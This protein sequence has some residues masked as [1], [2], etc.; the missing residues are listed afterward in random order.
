[1]AHQKHSLLITSMG[2]L[3]GQNIVEMLQ[4]RRHAFH[5]AGLNTEAV[6][7]VIFEGD[8]LWKSPPSASDAYPDFLIRVIENLQPDFVLPGRDSDVGILAEIRDRYPNWS[9]RIPVGTPEAA[10]IMDDKTLSAKFAARNGLPFARSVD[11]NVLSGDP[12]AS[13]ILALGFPQIAKPRNGFG[14]LGARYLIDL[15]QALLLCSLSPGEY[16]FQE[17]IDPPAGLSKHIERYLKDQHAGIPAF[18]HLPDERQYA[19]Q[20]MI[21]PLGNIGPICCSRS[22]MVIGRCERSEVIIDPEMEGIVRRYARA[23]A[24]I[25]WRGPFNIQGRMSGWGF[26]AVEMNGRFSGSTS[27]RGWM[28]HDEIRELYLAFRGLDIG[29]NPDRPMEQEGLVLRVLSDRHIRFRDKATF[30][31]TGYWQTLP[32]SQ[33]QQN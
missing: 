3:V 29:P 31:Q 32:G 20:C 16:I 12:L 21:D 1:M 25:G 17:L 27:A 15:D 23:M 24:G 9:D 7:P 6:N 19:G 26:V 8:E 30:E 13:A 2:S 14:S 10:G 5:I 11:P 28:G 4:G 18:F 33:S 22:T